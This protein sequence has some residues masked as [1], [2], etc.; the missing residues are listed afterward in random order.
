MSMA[1]GVRTISAARRSG[2]RH[3]RCVRSVNE[4]RWTWRCH[5]SNGCLVATITRSL[6]CPG[7]P[8]TIGRLGR[9]VTC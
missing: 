6:F 9:C 2:R 1:T 3:S 5:C 7:S 8:R 4:Q